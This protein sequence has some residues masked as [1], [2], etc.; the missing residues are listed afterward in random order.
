MDAVKIIEA[1]RALAGA[2]FSVPTAAAFVVGC[3]CGVVI[4][5]FP[6][7][8]AGQGLREHGGACAWFSFKW[9]R[10]GVGGMS[11]SLGVRGGGVF[12]GER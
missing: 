2:G 11:V 6:C 8:K 5:R 4:G 12:P 3:L 1:C 7:M 10:R 9:N